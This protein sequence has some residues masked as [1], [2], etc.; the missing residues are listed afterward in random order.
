[1]FGLSLLPQG[2]VGLVALLSHTL[3]RTAGVEDVLEVASRQHAI[4]VVA[5]VGLDVEVHA[6]VALIGVAVVD[7]L[8][9]E[10]FLLDDV[11]RGMG[12]DAGR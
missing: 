12:L 10:F 1:M 7:D 11:S 8:L 4:A 6:A 9:D 3:E 5:V 2:K